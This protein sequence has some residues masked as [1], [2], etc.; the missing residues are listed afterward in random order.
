MAWGQ[1]AHPWRTPRYEVGSS[2]CPVT[3]VSLTTAD[4]RR[5]TRILTLIRRFRMPTRCEEALL[6]K[7]REEHLVRAATVSNGA[8][9]GSATARQEWT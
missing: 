1:T 8:Y 5:I 2:P 6:N 3:V 7:L 4:R 9:L